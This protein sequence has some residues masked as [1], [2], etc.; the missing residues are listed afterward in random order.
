MRSNIQDKE[1]AG[2][3]S[4]SLTFDSA[5]DR[6]DENGAAK[7]LEG[8]IWDDLF[9]EKVSV[10]E[11]RV[12]ARLREEDIGNTEN[13]QIPK[14][15]DGCDY[16][17]LGHL[18]VRLGVGFESFHSEVQARLCRTNRAFLESKKTYNDKGPSAAAVVF[19]EAR[20]IF[21]L[22]NSY[23]IEAL[24]YFQ[25]DGWV[26]DHIKILQDL[27][28]LYLALEGFEE[29]PVRLE[30]MLL[31]RA[32]MLDPICNVI[33]MTIFLNLWRLV[34]FECG[35]IYQKLYT[36]KT[37]GNESGT[38][39]ANLTQQDRTK[40]DEYNAKGILAFQTFI[41]SFEKNKQKPD[42][43]EDDNLRP[44]VMAQLYIARS[45][46]R[47]LT[48]DRDQLIETHTLAVKMY[49]D[50]DEYAKAN[51]DQMNKPGIDLHTE[52]KVAR[53]MLALLPPKLDRLVKGRK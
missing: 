34:S 18:R 3:E 28:Q 21:K 12:D 32:R 14:D 10:E 42:T 4:F 22:S 35:E 26:T 6:H 44:Y 1:G 24:D 53:E 38:D 31:R 33:N 5:T 19:E 2:D 9:P 41:K 46:T 16:V 25:M 45:Y 52:L 50:I 8:I 23:Y 29:N 30:K 49:Q 48:T 39:G 27:S 51:E 15:D 43:I 17:Q 36:L 40:A 11:D 47:F 7:R 20:E 13:P 37:E